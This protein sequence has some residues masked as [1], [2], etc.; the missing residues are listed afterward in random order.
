MASIWYLVVAL[1]IVAYV[2]LDG[3][4]IGAGAIHL[5]AAKTDEDRR[6]ILNAIGPV[7]DGNEVWLL[8]AG[9]VLYFAFPP[10]ALNFAPTV[11]AT[12]G[13]RFLMLSFPAQ[14]SC[15]RSFTERRWGTLSG[16]CR[17]A[18]MATSSKPCGRTGESVLLRAFW[19]GTQCWRAWL[20][21]W[22][23]PFMVRFTLR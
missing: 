10:S 5:I 4:D 14:A 21:W 16:V 8:A 13:E 9:G 18:T 1:M 22:R 20:R 19:I 15:W 11:P 12:F 7:W 23:S 6:S 2:V 3:F 17:W